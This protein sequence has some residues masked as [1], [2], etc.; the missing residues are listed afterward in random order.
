[1]YRPGLFATSNGVMLSTANRN[2]EGTFGNRECL[3]CIWFSPVTAIAGAD[4]G[5]L[6]P[7]PRT[8][9]SGDLTIKYVPPVVDMGA[10]TAPLRLPKPPRW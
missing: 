3:S 7:N 2:F 10:Y 1:M 5:R 6:L 8:L 9:F 4:T